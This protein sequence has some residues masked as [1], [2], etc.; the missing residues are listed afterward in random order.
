MIELK[1]ARDKEKMRRAGL[2]V[3]EVLQVLKKAVK[4][5]MMTKELDHIADYEIRS[6][7]AVPVFKGYHGYPAS[8]C[9]SVNHEVVHGIPGP[10][11]LKEHDLVSVDLGAVID[12]FV[13]DAALS[14]FVGEPPD[15]RAALLLKVTEESLYAG[16]QAAQSGGHLGD[17]SHTVQQY[18]ERHG[19]SVVR[20]YVGHGIGHQM[21]EDPQVPNYGLPGR[22][23]LLKPG[24]ALAIEPMVNAGDYEVDVLDDGWTVVTRD[25]SL[26]AHFEHTIFITETGPE[27][28][29]R[30]D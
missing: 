27:I 11:R 20:D 8:V 10:R 5:G 7:G 26:S 13:G 12:S 6:R 14:L 18:V 23:I 9:V 30:I 3:A 17:I 1:S 19:F 28:L 25:G 29:T 16:I 21:H 15:E 2:I 4:P 24:L 22:G